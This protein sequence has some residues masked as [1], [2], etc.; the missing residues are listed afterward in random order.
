MFPYSEIRD[1][2]G[3]IQLYGP[4]GNLVD[5]VTYEDRTNLDST[6]PDVIVFESESTPIDHSLQRINGKWVGPLA[7]PRAT[8]LAFT[9]SSD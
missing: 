6:A 1:G 3:Y 9:V 5:A 2:P 7:Q 4:I 8:G